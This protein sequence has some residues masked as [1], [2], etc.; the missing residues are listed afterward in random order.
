MI[1]NSLPK[2][3]IVH[4]IKIRMKIISDTQGALYD[5]NSKFIVY[6]SVEKAFKSLKIDQIFNYSSLGG[7]EDFTKTAM[8]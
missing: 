4:I 5:D 1:L 8:Q 3:I 2:I 7:N 6:K